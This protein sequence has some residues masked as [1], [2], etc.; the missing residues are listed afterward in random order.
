M[1][2][3]PYA[4]QR[5]KFLDRGSGEPIVF[6]HNGALGHR[7]WDY[8]IEHFAAAH[9]VVAPDFVGHGESD[10]PVGVY[11]ADDFVGQVEHLADHL[12]LGRFH[13]VG[14]CLGGSVALEYARRCPARIRT[15]SL[16]T[17]ATPSVIASGPLGLFE[18]VSRPGTRVRDRLAR[19]AESPVGT[20]LMTKSMLRAQCGPRALSDQSFREYVEHAY[21]SPG[22][23]RVFCNVVYASFAHLDDLRKPPGFPPTLLMWGADNPILKSAAGR[24]LA[25][26]LMPQRTE[27]WDGCGYMLMRERPTD[28]NRVI[29][30][31]IAGNRNDEVR[32]RF[33]CGARS[34][35]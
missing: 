14:C 9:R 16:I 23:W 10:R 15:L 31:F 34:M 7:L 17:A 32:N 24:Q 5:V 8:Q 29:A 4:G 26:R 3:I 11:R 6:L 28:T 20:W 21:R 1:Q 30:E 27:F 2:T 25:G 12:G 35:P 33:D 13:L 19:Y 22:E 18:R